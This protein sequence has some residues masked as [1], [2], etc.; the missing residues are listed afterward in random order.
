M[1]F[2]NFKKENKL[3][4]DELSSEY[5]DKFGEFV[6]ILTT[7]DTENEYYLKMIRDAIDSGKHL[8]R[9]DLANVFMTKE[10]KDILY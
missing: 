1:K 6:P 8:T 7:V 10:S 5:E 9:N 4:F 3:S 2:E